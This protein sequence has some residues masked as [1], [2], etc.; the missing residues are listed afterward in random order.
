[1][2]K[3]NSLDA[4]LKDKRKELDAT[5][6]E[7]L[8]LEEKARN[9]AK[10]STSTSE[11]VVSEDPF[12]SHNLERKLRIA[13]D[14]AKSMARSIHTAIYNSS[15]FRSEPGCEGCCAELNMKNTSFLLSTLRMLPKCPSR[16]AQGHGNEWMANSHRFS[17]AQLPPQGSAPEAGYGVAQHCPQADDAALDHD[18]TSN[19]N[20]SEVCG[21]WTVG[22]CPSH[23]SLS[24]MA[25]VTLCRC[26]TGQLRRQTTRML[27]SLPWILA[28]MPLCDAHVV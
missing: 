17:E 12:L 6:A 9:A 2:V 1:M 3:Y 26:L 16:N 28:H 13:L 25:R 11:G 7:E 5:R 24:L 4:Y 23:A 21:P 14:F 18:L 19:S 22:A 10:A 8:K 15:V 27:Q 20:K